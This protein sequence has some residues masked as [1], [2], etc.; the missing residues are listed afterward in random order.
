MVTRFPCQACNAS[1]AEFAGKPH[2]TGF[3]VFTNAI[4][5]TGVAVV[6]GKILGAITAPVSVPAGITG[7]VG[8]LSIDTVRLPVFAAIGTGCAVGCF[9]NT[10]IAFRARCAIR[11]FV[12]RSTLVTVGPGK[13]LYAMAAVVSSPIRFANTGAATVSATG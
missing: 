8:I 7:A 5:L 12:P 10:M 11:A 13:I 2:G 9:R 6:T 3:A 1:G 4:S